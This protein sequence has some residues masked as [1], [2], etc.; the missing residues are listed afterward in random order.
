MIGVQEVVAQQVTAPELNWWLDDQLNP[1]SLAYQADQIL[2]MKIR[3]KNTATTAKTYQIWVFLANAQSQQQI[4]GTE[5]VLLFDG[6]D[7]VSIDPGTE[8]EASGPVNPTELATVANIALPL[9]VYF[10]LAVIDVGT[11]EQVAGRAVLLAGAVPSTFE[12][13]MPMIGMVVMVGM[14]GAIVP[15]MTGMLK[16]E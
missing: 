4:P 7:H 10:A 16:K 11:G 5:A 2:Q 3:L 12:Q 14:M 13:M 9:P 8:F 15:M 1:E 6:I